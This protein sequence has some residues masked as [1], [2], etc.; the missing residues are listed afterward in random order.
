MK[1]SNTKKYSVNSQTEGTTSQP[2]R[3]LPFTDHAFPLRRHFLVYGGILAVLFYTALIALLLFVSRHALWSQHLHSAY[4]RATF[5]YRDIS[6]DLLTPRG[7][8][9]AQI[10]TSDKD[11]MELLH[12]E[13]TEITDGLAVASQVK[14]IRVDG[15]VL[16]DNKDTSNEGKLYPD[17][18]ETGF[19]QALKGE[20]FFTLEEDDAGSLLME[21]YLPVKNPTTGHIEGIFE[22]YEPVTGFY[23]F[24]HKTL[25]L[26][27]GL[28][29]LVLVIFSL[30]LYRIIKKADRI[31]SSNTDLLRR[32]R[33]HMAEFLPDSAIAAIWEAGS[34]GNII[35][36]GERRD[37]IVFFSDV[38]GFTSYSE[39]NAPEVVVGQLNE[40]FDLQARIIYRCEGWIDKFVG[41]EI[42]ALFKDPDAAVKAA[43][44]IICSITAVKDINL[45]IGVG[46]AKGHAIVGALGTENRRDY[47]VIGDVVNTGARL[48]AQAEPGEVLISE[49]LYS[50]L[51][52]ELSPNFQVTKDFALK[53]KEQLVKTR[54]WF[55]LNR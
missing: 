19:L 46:I 29:S 5:I 22:L 28:P 55:P 51:S 44:E 53:G 14:L 15:M 26:V 21:I 10:D 48:C 8:T 25:L 31:I 18:T 30:M 3:T 33:D 12:D 24:L 32:V 27:L 38:R 6:K 16:C 39:R 11:L 36:A 43:E 41:D 17:R 2:A 35:G 49:A 47:S 9:L 1:L 42:F 40:I 7:L 23:A 13:I 4:N 45:R 37:V 20:T 34:A 50:A 54:S 52:R